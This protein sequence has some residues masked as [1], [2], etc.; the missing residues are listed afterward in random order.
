MVVVVVVVVVV[1]VLVLVLV[2]ELC[3]KG[4]SSSRG[5]EEY[6]FI[7]PWYKISIK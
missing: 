5:T 1:L 6:I 4:G 3:S 7:Y 2:V